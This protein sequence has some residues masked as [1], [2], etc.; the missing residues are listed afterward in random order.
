VLTAIAGAAAAANLGLIV[1]DIL[2]ERWGP[3]SRVA[4]TAPAPLS[5]AAVR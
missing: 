2:R 1:V 4:A 3:A 5:Q